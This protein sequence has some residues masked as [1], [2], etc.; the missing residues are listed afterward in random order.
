MLT[1]KEL[2]SK[3]NLALNNPTKYVS[4]SSNWGRYVNGKF[5][6][7]CCLLIKAIGW[8]WD[9]D[10]KAVHGGAIYKSN[11]V[12]DY[13]CY[14]MIKDCTEVST[15]FNTII[16]GELVYMPDHV[17]IYVGDGKVIECTV[18]WAKDCVVKSEI[19]SNGIRT[20]DNKRP[21]H[22]K[23]EKHGLLKWIKY[24]GSRTILEWQ[25]CAIADGYTSLY[26]DGEWGKYSV[27]CSQKMVISKG[28]RYKNL[29]LFLQ[30]LL[31]EKGFYTGT[32]DGVC[33]EFTVNAIKLFQ[34]TNN[35]LC[36]GVVGQYTWK[37]LLGV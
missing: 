6:F 18:A 31:K 10:K 20:L 36:D 19:T 16:P 27:K 24:L 9:A 11:N 15:D 14:N 17:G 25:K 22:Y 34:S 35:L 7:D 37:K 3:L 29:C 4:P 1:S 33:G 30:K 32:L 28:T 23:W 8:G 26:P 21:V 13:S 2:I 12:P 5:I